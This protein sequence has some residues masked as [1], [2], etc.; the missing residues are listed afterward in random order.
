MIETASERIH[1]IFAVANPDK[2]A[3]ITPVESKKLL[4]TELGA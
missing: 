3:A 4:Q 2:L 1:W